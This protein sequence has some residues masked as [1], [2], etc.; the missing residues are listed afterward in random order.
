ME[1]TVHLV[2]LPLIWLVAAA[3]LAGVIFYL[4]KYRLF[5]WSNRSAPAPS[6][7]S[8]DW[9][10]PSVDCHAQK[11]SPLHNWDPRLK[12]VS[13]LTFWFC[14]A[15][16]DQ[17]P[18]CFLALL[19]ALITVRLAKIP[20][21][22]SLKRI[23]ALAGFISMFLVIMPLTVPTRPGDHLIIIAP[24]DFFSFN[25]RG[26]SIALRIALKASAIALLMDPALG[27]SPFPVTL[28][29]LSQ[30]KVPQIICQMLSLAHRYIFVFQHESKRMATGMRARGFK[31]GTN[32]ETLK[33]MGN[34][35]GMLF[36]RSFERTERVYEAMLA[37][38]YS[39]HFPGMKK[40]HA[41]RKDWIKGLIWVAAGMALLISDR[42]LH[43]RL[44][45]GF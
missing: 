38:G 41:Q 26:F 39:G 33:T 25:L 7:Q 16:I 13:F 31:Q 28:N 18:P 19:I 22:T 20:P 5:P 29:A 2:R 4:L 32:L 12:I 40:F 11:D 23:A 15:S 6:A 24:L 35:I 36:V 17:L 21:R 45:Y 42:L 3:A 34:F 8:R 14:V 30:L 37:R 1:P 27:T 9:S 44:P 10:I 43:L